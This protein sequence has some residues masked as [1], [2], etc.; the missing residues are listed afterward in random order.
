MIQ[1]TFVSPLRGIASA[2]VPHNKREMS[3]SPYQGRK[4][5][6]GDQKER[7]GAISNHVPRADW[8]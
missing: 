7:P 4:R 1:P 8:S 6:L 2:A 5:T 3:S